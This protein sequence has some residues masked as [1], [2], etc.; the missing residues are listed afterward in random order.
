MYRRIQLINHYDPKKHE[1]EQNDFIHGLMG[2]C[3]SVEIADAWTYKLRGSNHAL[4]TNARFYFTEKGWKEV[5]REVIAACQRSG[6]DYRVIKVKETDAQVVWRD[7]YTEYE[8]AI[9]P[10][11]KVSKK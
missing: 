11:R 10:K 8:V 2:I 7:K 1:H 6:Q 3:N 5:G 9:Q 4:P